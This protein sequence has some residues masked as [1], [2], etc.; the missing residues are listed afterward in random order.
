MAKG[1]IDLPNRSGM[2]DP[3]ISTRADQQRSLALQRQFLTREQARMS[4]PTGK[5]S[6]GR[7]MLDARRTLL[8]TR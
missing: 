4:A 8:G 5:R 1:D 7:R 6:V 2:V 3:T